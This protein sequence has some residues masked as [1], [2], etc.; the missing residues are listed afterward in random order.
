MEAI[1]MPDGDYERGKKIFKAR[2]LMCHVI[3]SDAMKTGPSL[4]K[5]F[6]RKAGTVKGYDYS[7]ANKNAN[8]VWTKEILFDYLAN[9]KKYLPGSKMIF[10]GLKK[11][12]DRA[13]VIKYMEVESSK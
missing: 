11:A 10:A 4:Y 2:C 3:D 6:G 12:E 5:I 13:D 8:I 7:S 9:P 1:E